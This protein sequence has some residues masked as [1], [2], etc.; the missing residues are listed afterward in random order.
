MFLFLAEKYSLRHV[1]DR[2]RVQ[3]ETDRVVVEPGEAFCWQ[4]TMENGKA[5]MVPFL[6]VRESVPEGLCFAPEGTSVE[7]KPGSGYFTTLYLGGKEKMVLTRQV[8]LPNRGRY[9]FRG[10]R[11]RAGD[12]MGLKDT[13]QTQEALA[14]VVVKPKRL[15]SLTLAQTLGGF[16]GERSVEHSLWEDPVLTIGF[17]DYTG[18]EPFRAISW[19]ES[20]RQAH[21]V[22]RQYDHTLEL[23]CT[24][25]FCISSDDREKFELCC[26]AARQV[27]ETLEEQR[28]AYDFQTNA[29]IAGTMGNWRS[30]GNGQGRGHLETVLEGLGRMT[31]QS[32]TEAADWLYAVGKGLSGRRSLLLLVPERTEELDGPLTYLRE[33]SGSEVFVFD[34][35]QEEV[36]A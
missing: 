16:L 14:E 35:S 26:Q 5:M 7:E 34:A 33:R 3:T 9:F 31:G 18:R 19:M 15:S 21:L 12:L 1:F 29:V 13:V 17:R 6:E 27:C 2:L 24:V 30:V 10:C 36:E 28:I 11:L 22:V 23:S 4:L 25:L 20:A 8:S 32:R